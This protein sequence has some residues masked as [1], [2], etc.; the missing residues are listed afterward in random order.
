VRL[1]G[2]PSLVNTGSESTPPAAGD[3]G[4]PGER[5]EPGAL[6]PGRPRRRRRAVLGLAAGAALLAILVAGPW[7]W[8][9]LSSRDHV[10]DLED[11]PS[12]PVALVLGAGLNPDGSP[13][14][15]LAGRL[16]VAKALYDSG[17]ARVILV[18][19]DNRVA[20]HDEPTAM[21]DWLLARGIPTGAVVRDFAGRDTYDSCTRAGRI[22]GVE[23]VLVVSQG[24]HLPRAVT[25]CRA[26]GLDAEG[27]GDR[28]ARRYPAQWT[29]GERREKLAVAKTVLDV[30]TGRDPVLGPV[31]TSVQEALA[32]SATGS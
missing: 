19:G 24:Y 31:E 3:R 15:F 14:P 27:V 22:F 11:A 30:V 18:S 25:T 10:H 21:R 29:A 6:P 2:Y 13:S 7:A 28:T 12:A 8:V 9:S 1:R 26:V 4:R 32:A 17:R 5:D 16:E 23:R 20:S